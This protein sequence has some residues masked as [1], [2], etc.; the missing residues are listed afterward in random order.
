M[1]SKKEVERKR[2]GSTEKKGTRGKKEKALGKQT[3]F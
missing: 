3:L 2:K 1:R